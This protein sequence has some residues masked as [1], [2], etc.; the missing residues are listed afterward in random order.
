[1]PKK[2]SDTFLYSQHGEYEKKLFKYLMDSEEIDKDSDRFADIIYEVKRQQISNSLLNVLKSKNV[3]LM[4]PKDSLPKAF[5]VFVGKDI[6]KSND[7][8][9]FIDC[10]EIISVGNDGKYRC[11]NIDIL[12][13]YLVSAMNG[14]IYY[15][16]ETKLMMNN[17]LTEAGTACFSKLFTHIIDYLYKISSVPGLITKARYYGAVYYQAAILGKDY[18]SDSVKNIACKISGASDR[19]AE[20]YKLPLTPHDFLNIKFFLE[21]FAQTMRFDKLTVD[22]FVEKWMY[23]YGVGTVFGTEVYPAFASMLTDTY[24]GA[25]I[26]NQK[27]IE[28]VTGKDMVQFVKT[29][30]QIGDDTK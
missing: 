15:G 30:L 5:K 24:I 4:S 18:K 10:S 9:A 14:L 11:K 12:I 21:R 27:T 17:T 23:L 7:M 20:M 26:N 22:V 28:K 29:L 16:A 25:Y 2:Y 1:M 19:E 8:K 3:I 13:A 6:K